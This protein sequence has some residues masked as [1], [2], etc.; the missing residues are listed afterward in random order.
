LEAAA[1][2]AAKTRDE[3]DETGRSIFGTEDGRGDVLRGDELWDEEAV[4]VE[5]LFV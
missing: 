4:N 1:I 2:E 3:T 5:E